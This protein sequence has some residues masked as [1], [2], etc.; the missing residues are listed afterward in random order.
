M[1][2]LVIYQ[3]E[4]DKGKCLRFEREHFVG[5]KWRIMGCAC[6]FIY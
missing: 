1:K 3:R 4:V 6:V 2:Q 5:S